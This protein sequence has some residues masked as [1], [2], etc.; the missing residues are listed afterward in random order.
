MY[1]SFQTIHSLMYSTDVFCD[2]NSKGD[3]GAVE[4]SIHCK[5]LEVMQGFMQD[6]RRLRCSFVLFLFVC[7]LR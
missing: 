7:L 1:W 6:L 3:M 2:N 4:G 5:V